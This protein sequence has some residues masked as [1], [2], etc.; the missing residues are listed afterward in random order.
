MKSS[1]RN[2]KAD[3]LFRPGDLAILAKTN[4]VNFM[5]LWSTWSDAEY[6][7]QD[8]TCWPTIAGR[9]EQK[10][11]VLIVEVNTSHAGLVGVRICTPHNTIGWISCKCLKKLN[12]DP[13]EV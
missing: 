5:V 3:Q 10:D 6:V 4:K 9:V 11:V 13:I 8:S 1:K 2:E 12:G 7:F